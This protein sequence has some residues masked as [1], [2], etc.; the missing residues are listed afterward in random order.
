MTGEV[1]SAAQVFFPGR[2]GVFDATVVWRGTPG[3]R[4]D[5]ALLRVDDTSWQAPAG[6][7]VRWGR[8]VTH[9]TEIECTTAGVPEVVQ[10]TGQPVDMLQPSGTFNPGDRY[11]ADRYLVSL[12]QPAPSNARDDS[13]WG[14]LSGAGLFSG[15]RADLLIG[16]MATDPVGW[17]HARLEAVPA[18]VLHQDEKFRAAL[19][20]HAG[21]RAAVV[22]EPVEW[23]GL[24][25]AGEVVPPGGLSGSPAE[26]LR[27]R[28]EATPFRGRAELMR[29]LRAWA[30]QGSGTAA[31]LVHGPGGQGKTRLAARLAGE[32]SAAGWAVMWL[33]GQA[34]DLRDLADAAVPLLLIIDY[35][36]TRPAQ[37]AAVAEAL[38]RHSGASPVRILLLART[39]DGWWQQAQDASPSAEQVLGVAQ[40]TRLP[41][42]DT[43]A[44]GRRDAYREAVTAFAALLRD[45]PGSIGPQDNNWGALAERLDPPPMAQAATALA[46][47]MRA[48]ADLLDTA[49]AQRTDEQSEAA[50]DDAMEVEDRLLVHERRYWRTVAA[51]QGLS[52]VL[53]WETLTDAVAASVLVGADDHGEADEL[54]CRVP[55]LADQSR[56]IRDR[57][58]RWIAAL[59]P[60]S[61]SR[62]WDT[63]QPD[64][65]AERFIGRRLR[66]AP[67]LADLLATG[68]GPE[69]AMRLLTV[70][71]RAAAHPAF[72]GALNADLTRLCTS[73]PDEL[74]PAATHVATQVEEP[75]PLL[76]ALHQITDDPATSIDR[77]TALA[78]QLPYPSQTLADYAAQLAARM[79]DHYRAQANRDPDVFLPSLAA[80]LNNLSIRLGELGRWEEGLEAVAEAVGVYRRLAEGRPDAFLPSLAAS[81][82][83]LS[84]DLGEL[85]RR[86]EGLEAVV[87]AVEIRRRLAE[88]RPD[89]FLPSLATSLN[90]LS[91]RLREL[92][93]QEEG[94][95][96][97]AEAVGIW[98]QL[99]ERRPV[100]HQAELERSQRV[101]AW[102]KGLPDL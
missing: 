69:Q 12:T 67:G 50:A 44:E 99:V 94:L 45:M 90:N 56:D 77:L 54:L 72:G 84:V 14:G 25:D 80:C 6:A 101:M 79:T 65:L 53:G 64:R 32:L 60:P 33:S 8:T 97:I 2:E 89:A 78:D 98:Q 47:Q 38:A 35:A 71:A 66:D 83:N 23:T 5:A 22:L 87:E 7:G 59:Y 11:V 13:P 1:G 39:A 73:R 20:E 93:R 9:R 31:R 74:A 43:A 15:D 48:L 18:Y 26:L 36:E 82:N 24:A 86:E 52:E 92:G 4:N 102:L 51:A 34:A 30:Q 41:A 21:Q 3:G 96:T 57:V 88:V 62:P 91:V 76:Q 27:A 29:Q 40:V 61:P 17:G 46:V 16:V 42:L 85:G 100:V 81:L 19:V 37:V 49:T 63:L 10:R 28:R 75:T 68:C 58:R 95:E 55:G 70:Y